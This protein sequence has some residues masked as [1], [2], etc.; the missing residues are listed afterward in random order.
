MY[1]HIPRS[2]HWSFDAQ[3]KFVWIE[4]RRSVVCITMHAHTS[5]RYSLSPPFI[6][7]HCSRI[8]RSLPYYIE[9]LSASVSNTHY[10]LSP[11]LSLS[12]WCGALSPL[13]E[14]SVCLHQLQTRGAE[15]PAL[16]S[17]MM[18]LVPALCLV[19]S[20]MMC[21]LPAQNYK[22]Q[23]WTEYEWPIAAPNYDRPYIGHH[24]CWHRDMVAT[25]FR[26]TDLNL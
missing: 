3:M 7:R 13:Q 5:H 16:R 24:C 1:V 14:H 9:P 18:C 26:C 4:L 15:V 2:V 25:I 17:T 19:R 21:L 11:A 10:P 23:L 20:T 22:I 8:Y 6:Y 12:W